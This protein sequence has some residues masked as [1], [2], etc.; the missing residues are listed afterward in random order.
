MDCIFD[1]ETSGLP[2]RL[3]YNIYHDP[4]N[5]ECY[6][7][8]RIVSISWILSQNHNAVEHIYFIIK[9]ED[10][11]ISPES[12]SI[13][14][15][16]KE[17]ALLEGVSFD[18]MLEKFMFAIKQSKNLIAHNI[19]FDINVLKSELYRRNKFSE[20][21]ELN[22]KCLICTMNKGKNLMGKN[23]K[24]A[25]LYKYLYGQD[26]TNAHNA[27]ADTY[28][29]FQ[30]YKILFPK[31]EKKFFFN[32]KLIELTEE[33]Q[34]IVFSD[35]NKNILVIA[36]AG[37]G[38]TT[39]TLCRIKYLL[40]NG[41]SEESIMLTTFTRDASKSMTN[42]L[43]DI[44]G[45]NANIKVG[46]IDS[47]SKYYST[48]NTE[49]KNVG[50]YSNSFFNVIKT[51]P[52]I[53]EKYKY[54]FIDEFQDINET[55][56]NIIN[57]FYKN[58]TKIFCV[59]DDAQNIYSFRGSKIEYILNFEKHFENNEIFKLN[60]N[61]RSTHEIINFANAIIQNNKNQIP[62]IMISGNTNETSIEI[63]EKKPLIT[64]YPTNYLQINTIINEIKNL[65]K[66]GV[67]EHE[68][69]ILSPTN[70]SLFS[71]EE[72]LIKNDI[73]N[74]YLDSKS[75]IKPII[76]YKHVCLCT[77]HKSKGLEWDYVFIINISDSNF[78]KNKD[79]KD[80][81]ESR[82]LCY[83]AVT[84]AR[85]KL[86]LSYTKNNTESIPYISRFI[87]EINPRLY[88]TKNIYPQYLKGISS[89]STKIYEYSVTKLIKNLDGNDYLFMK[90]NSIIPT[91]KIEDIKIINIHN[92]YDY[93]KFIEHGDL[94][95]DFGIFIEKYIKREISIYKKDNEIIKDKHLKQYLANIKLTND[96]YNVYNIY[97]NNFKI[98]LKELNNM[99]DLINQDNILQ[100]L[101]KNCI[102]IRDEHYFI[103]KNI[104]NK[105]KK[106]SIKYNI[107]IENIPIFLKDFISNDFEK[108]INDDIILFNNLDIPSIN[109]LD[110]I[111]NISKCKKVLEYRRRLLF[112]DIDIKNIQEY[113]NMFNDISNNFIKFIDKINIKN[114]IICEQELQYQKVIG[115]LDL[116]IDDTIIDYKT[117]STDNITI[118]WFIQLL[119]YKVLCDK[120][121][122]YINNIA[123][124]NPLK[125]KIY[126]ID[127]SKWNGHDLLIK[128]L[129]DKRTELAS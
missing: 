87:S 51:R 5:I 101:N 54:L 102:K 18:Y 60:K 10:F 75:D 29:C 67:Q 86:Y 58:G 15:I 122:I 81:I 35:I 62:K 30:I 66:K 111:W 47:I 125:G 114:D 39:T 107:S 103:I 68:I 32:N 33:Q 97:K 118:D 94:Y 43:M 92:E 21:G 80:I 73:K 85:K 3:G 65:L 13:H 117:S 46:T 34:K 93:K 26:M 95:S 2:D 4:Q 37:S 38:K 49:I 91:F 12:E 89:I 129:L 42:K 100:I 123:I 120:N 27:Q 55:Q 104:L 48:T 109:I 83:V 23:P 41:I 96:E 45:Y 105:L 88:L 25:D 17:K 82:R 71:F 44:L 50:E 11:E 78:P 8:S 57:E 108:Q 69:C 126:G 124:Y 6:K 121:G 56:F 98:N 53:I 24:L 77:I 90:E 127:I 31:D 1:T 9:P 28:F 79:E 59:G 16:S 70:Y 61:F 22:N 116:R 76:K 113:S 128:Y 63:Y 19:N 36:C 84:R 52:N 20:L 115:E 72:N 74:V 110:K 119:C 7:N 99:N 14:G 40:D 64:Y 112:T 106:N